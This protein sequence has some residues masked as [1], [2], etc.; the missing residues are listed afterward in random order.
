MTHA[1]PEPDGVSTGKCDG[2]GVGTEREF[3]VQEDAGPKEKREGMAVGRVKA[4]EACEVE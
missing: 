2:R 1:A 4:E 3:E